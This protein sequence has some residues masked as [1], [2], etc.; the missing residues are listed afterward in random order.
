MRDPLVIEPEDDA[1]E[2]L[3][4]VAE[5]EGD[6]LFHKRFFDVFTNPHVGRVVESLGVAKVVLYGVALDVCNRYAVEG[7]LARHPKIAIT[8]VIDAVQPIDERRGAEALADWL[9]RGVTLKST[10][11]VL[12]GIY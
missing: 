5:H 11:Q 4:R 10:A 8:V 3:R 12:D 2:V 6:I 1:D 9:L 7:L